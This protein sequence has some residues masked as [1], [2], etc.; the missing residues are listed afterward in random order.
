[1]NRMLLFVFAV[2][3]P[4]AHAADP[5]PGVSAGDD[6]EGVTITA[7]K[8]GCTVA[9]TSRTGIGKT[10]LTRTAKEW[11]TAVVLR[12]HLKGL[13]GFRASNGRVTVGA[14]VPSSGGK[15]RTWQNIEGKE[16]PIAMSVKAVDAKGKP[17]A[18]LPP[19]GGYFEVVLPPAVL[20][21]DAKTITINW[22]DFYRR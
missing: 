6:A 5:S 14:E 20:A 17:M 18:G 13:E 22:I 9:I 2:L 21:A 7:T 4:S 1:M 12:L 19:A 8:A 11:P 16:Q 15:P 3:A 10:T